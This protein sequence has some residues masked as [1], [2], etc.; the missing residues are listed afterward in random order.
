MTPLTLVR[1]AEKWNPFFLTQT[2][3][4]GYEQTNKKINPTWKEVLPGEKS[5]IVEH[6]RYRLQHEWSRTKKKTLNENWMLATAVATCSPGAGVVFGWLLRLQ[7]PTQDSRPLQRCWVGEKA[8]AFPVSRSITLGVLGGTMVVGCWNHASS[9]GTHL[10]PGI[11]PFVVAYLWKRERKGKS[12]V[13]E[14]Q[15]MCFK[16]GFECGWLKEIFNDDTQIQIYEQIYMNYFTFHFLYDM[17][18]NFKS[19]LSLLKCLLN[20]I[21]MLIWKKMYRSNWKYLFFLYKKQN[22]CFV[23]SFTSHLICF[24]LLNK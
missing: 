21:Q 19:A 6:Y 2:E 10:C 15:F 22:F 9:T 5:I 3:H 23:K 24:A 16:V 20:K 12:W 7:S 1:Y 13:R 17:K 11:W 4:Y 8:L 18:I 14:V